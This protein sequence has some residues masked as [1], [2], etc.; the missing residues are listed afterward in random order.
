M[1]RFYFLLFVSSAHG[2]DGAF[3]SPL[4][5]F[6]DKG[7]RR[8]QNQAQTLGEKVATT[9]SEPTLT[10]L[11]PL[12]QQEPKQILGL[13]DKTSCLRFTTGVVLH[14]GLNVCN[15]AMCEWAL[16]PP[17]H[18]LDHFLR[19]WCTVPDVDKNQVQDERDSSVGTRRRKVGTNVKL[20]LTTCTWRQ[21]A[22]PTRDAHIVNMRHFATLTVRSVIGWRVARHPSRM[23]TMG[24]A[25]RVGHRNRIDAR[26]PWFGRSDLGQWEP[27]PIGS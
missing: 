1:P 12:S 16:R 27:I 22:Y 5:G 13:D 3:W 18:L 6:K 24:E 25:R 11:C 8:R 2:H 26:Q 19:E 21:V 7:Q 10:I 9:G 17:G 15:G 23:K 20:K 4:H 14:H